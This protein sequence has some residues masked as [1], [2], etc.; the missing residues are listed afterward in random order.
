MLV[1]RATVRP[2]VCPQPTTGATGRLV[3]TFPSLLPVAG[4]SVEWCGPHL[5]YLHTARLV[6]LLQWYLAK[7]ALAMVDPQGEHGQEWQA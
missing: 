7:G 4:L 2:D 1:G 5:G 6:V 3:C